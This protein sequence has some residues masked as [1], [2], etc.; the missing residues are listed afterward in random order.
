MEKKYTNLELEEA[1][2]SFWDKFTDL[3]DMDKESAW[4]A[5]SVAF[6]EFKEKLGWRYDG[7]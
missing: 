2:N 5:I 6:D 3:Y 7:D 4:A 1:V